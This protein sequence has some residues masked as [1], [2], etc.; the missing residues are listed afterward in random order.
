MADGGVAMVDE[1]KI[2]RMNIAHYE[3]MLKLDMNNDKRSVVQRLLV[4]AKESLAA[5]S[6]I[7]RS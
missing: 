2:I 1:S 5:A 7:G 6:R 4:Q 3:A